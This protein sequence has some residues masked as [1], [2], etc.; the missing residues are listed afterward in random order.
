ML[1]IITNLMLIENAVFLKGQVLSE[2]NWSYCHLHIS[3][4]IRCLYDL[5]Q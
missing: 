1:Q 4:S 3:S 5:L 2:V